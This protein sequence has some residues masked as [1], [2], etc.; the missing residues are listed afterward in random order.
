MDDILTDPNCYGEF[1]NQEICNTCEFR[2]S[3][4]FYTKT[5]NVDA[6]THIISFEAA[7]G[8]AELAVCDQFFDEKSTNEEENIFCLLSR[9]FSYILD[10]DEYTLGVLLE[11]MRPRDANSHSVASLAGVRNCSRQAMHRKILD[12]IS[13]RPE[14]IIVFSE[15]LKKMSAARINFLHKRVKKQKKI[16]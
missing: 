15:V 1:S 12:I 16:R 5:K 9:F 8:I 14:L 6:R 10:L 13:S 3:C 7:Q 2:I 11:V 4:E